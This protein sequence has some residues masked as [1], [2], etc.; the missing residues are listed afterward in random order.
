ME[1]ALDGS[2]V[3]PLLSTSR[4]EYSAAW[5]PSG[6]QY[7]YVSNS[8]GLPAIWVRS[9]A[10]GWARPFAEHNADGYLDQGQPRFSP[11]GQ[12][13]AY[14]RTGARHAVYVSNLS[15]GQA[16]PIE[17][18]TTDQ[19]T[20]AWSPDGNWI[21]YSRYVGEKWEVAKAPSGG[22]GQ[23][24]RLADGGISGG[25]IE[26]SPAGTWIAIRDLAGLELVPAEG[27]PARRVGPCAA[28]AFSR[29]GSVLYVLRRAPDRHWELATLSAPDGA[30][31]KTV[32]LN[33]P[34][35]RTIR[36]MSLHPDGSRL[37][38]SVGSQ[39]R[40]IWILDGF[41]AAR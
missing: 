31:R 7:A 18:Q 19:H 6:L 39:N 1:I 40:D 12:R 29:D 17:R 32:A 5:S 23:P 2:K 35:E 33:L 16:V 41:D 15:G 37:V 14:V 38:V 4:T 9:V 8:S 11:D 21:A 20:P 34:H 26:W 13:L 3:S 27:G 30:V 36:D 22:G 25:W 24:V 10:E 28:F